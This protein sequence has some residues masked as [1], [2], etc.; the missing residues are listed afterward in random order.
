MNRFALLDAF[1]NALSQHHWLTDIEAEASRFRTT[2]S[3]TSDHKWD[4]A[5]VRI[6]EA[7]KQRCEAQITIAECDQVTL[8]LKMGRAA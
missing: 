3:I 1:H 8:G 7:H 2:H 4:A 6:Q 5:L